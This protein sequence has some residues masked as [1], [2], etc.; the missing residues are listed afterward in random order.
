MRH[1]FGSADYLQLSVI[2]II[3]FSAMVVSMTTE[4]TSFITHWNEYGE[5]DGYASKFFILFVFP[6]MILVFYL[7][8]LLVPYLSHHDN[9]DDFYDRYGDFRLAIIFFLAILY[10]SIILQSSGIVFNLNYVIIPCFSLLF[11]YLG[12]LLSVA[13]PNHYIGFRTRWTLRSE[14]VWKKT[15][16][17]GGFA[18]KSFAFV[19]LLALFYSEQFLLIFFV[20]LAVV[21]LLIYLYSHR[22]HRRYAAIPASAS[23]VHLVFDEVT[24]VRTRPKQARPAVRRMTSRKAS[25]VKRKPVAV[26]KKSR[27]KTQAKRRPASKKKKQASLP[28][29]KVKGR[30]KRSPSARG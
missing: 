25:A 5:P 28:K 1:H 7:V 3:F 17:F 4:S 22:M 15:H 12:H 24:S 16:V 27:R 9:L 20:P 8:F 10:Y 30:T 14:I 11:F 19:L 13:Q 23:D 2:L 18:L 29:R 21:L 26:R 6:V